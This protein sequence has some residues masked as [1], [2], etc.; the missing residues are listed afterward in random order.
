MKKTTKIAAGRYSLTMLGSTYS[1]EREGRGTS[2][3]V[4]RWTAYRNARPARVEV[5][6]GYTKAEVVDYLNRVEYRRLIDEAI[7]ES[8]IT[9]ENLMNDLRAEFED[10]DDET[11]EAAVAKWT[12]GGVSLLDVRN[13]LHAARLEENRFSVDVKKTSD[14]GRSVYATND[15]EGD[16]REIASI[17]GDSKR[18]FSIRFFA[19]LSG[20]YTTNT[21]AEAREWAIAKVSE[22]LKK[23][24]DATVARLLAET[25]ATGRKGGSAGDP[26]T[27]A[28]EN[29]GGE[30]AVLDRSSED[31]YY[32]P[33]A[34]AIR[35]ARS[36]E[37]SD[38]RRQ[39]SEIEAELK[40]AARKATVKELQ[41]YA[42]AISANVADAN[43]GAPRLTDGFT[44]DDFRAGF[45]TIAQDET[46]RLIRNL[47]LDVILEKTGGTDPANETASA[48]RHDDRIAGVVYRGRV[49]RCWFRVIGD[50]VEVTI[51]TRAHATKRLPLSSIVFDHGSRATYGDGSLH[52]REF[53]VLTDAELLERAPFEATDFSHVEAEVVVS[54]KDRARVKVD[55]EVAGETWFDG[56]N[57]RASVAGVVARRKFLDRRRA[58]G[59][60]AVETNRLEKEAGR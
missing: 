33:K 17:V 20:D 19:P 51:P 23:A 60:V 49:Y 29:A 42:D 12:A 34:Y 35:E 44:A 36:K 39:F 40:E 27:E 48:R 13:D 37:R 30:F 56:S 21:I 59:F 1:I 45:R 16:R 7:E 26:I 52:S 47:V 50:E 3:D 11:V 14:L 25:P 38:A 41:R 10:V 57:W 54:I 6:T 31:D 8:R 9:N 24:H 4:T 53:R 55:G 58:I 22:E 28:I 43:N 32:S 2:T 18:G 15:L 5:F 46:S